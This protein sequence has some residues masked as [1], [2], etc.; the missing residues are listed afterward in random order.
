MNKITY[1]VVESPNPV[2]DHDARLTTMTFH[3]RLTPARQN[4]PWRSL[5]GWRP[6]QIR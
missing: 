2:H 5:I 4:S 1:C 6:K 3:R